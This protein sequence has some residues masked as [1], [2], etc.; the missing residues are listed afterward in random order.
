MLIFKSRDSRIRNIIGRSFI[1]SSVVTLAIALIGSIYFNNS[2]LQILQKDNLQKEQELLSN[3]LV[4]ALI[5]ADMT[6]VRRL[7]S[8][9]SDANEKFV[10]IDNSENILMPNYDDLDLIKASI[11]DKNILPECNNVKTGYQIIKGNKLW[12]NCSPLT[13][14][15]I[16]KRRIAGIL[17]S[18]S[19]YPSLWFSSLV[20][21]FFGIAVISLLLNIFWLGRVLHKK[22]LNPLTTLGARLIEA[23]RSPFDSGIYLDDV[24]DLPHEIQEIKDAFQG[25]LT[26]LHTEYRQRTESEKK[27]ALLDQ[28]AR[29][30]HDIRS[31]IAVME[32]SLYLLAQDISKEKMLMI[33]TAIQSVRDIANNLLEQYRDNQQAKISL[34]TSISSSHDN[35]NLPRSIL[36]HSLIEQIISQ[37]KHEWLQKSCELTFTFLPDTKL[38]WINVTPGDVKRMISNL[39]NNAIEACTNH[40]KIHIELI[41]TASIIELCITDNG[42]GIPTDKIEY[43][44]HGESSKHPGKGLG[45]SSAKQYME[46]IGGKLL[47][48]SQLSKG[49]TVRLT[50]LIALNPPWHPDQIDLLKNNRVIVLDDD[51][52]M[53]TLW[54]HRLKNYPVKTHLFTNYGETIHWIKQNHDQLDKMVFLIDYELSEKSVN[55]LML[56]KYLNAQGSSYLITSHAEEVNIQKEIEN[57]GAWL[58]PK[59]FASEIPI[60]LRE[61]K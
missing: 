55:G 2:G 59:K 52:A 44:L 27:S 24:K 60:S 31:P 11:S 19:P 13:I 58:I 35:R 29:V 28:A 22:L 18:F 38:V 23:A 14:N 4:P 46:S 40:A 49:T 30:A 47:I 39:L 32:T 50:F 6:E 56:L 57:I 45:L 21:Y 43:F 10:V 37:K 5:I 26:H 3:I 48:T 34:N 51:M 15:S 9:A 54:I 25:V 1:F 17:I 42:I 20:F 12:I 53:Q 8:L 33:Q 36:L 61:F 7:L 41:K 16:D